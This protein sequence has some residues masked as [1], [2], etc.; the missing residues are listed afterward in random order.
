MITGTHALVLRTMDRAREAEE[1]EKELTGRVARENLRL[2]SPLLRLRHARASER[3]LAAVLS[4]AGPV[5]PRI[6]VE[7]DDVVPERAALEVPE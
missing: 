7:A 3:L 2:A 6:R 1:L 5:Y 4:P